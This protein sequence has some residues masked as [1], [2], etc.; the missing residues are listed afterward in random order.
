MSVT[1]ARHKLGRLV[2][3]TGMTRAL[4]CFL[5][6]LLLLAL[7]LHGYAASTMLLCAAGHHRSMASADGGHDPA[8]HAAVHHSARHDNHAAGHDNH[9]AGHDNHA[10]GHDNYAAKP[11]S[12]D[13]KCSACAACCTAVYLPTNVI[14]FTAPAPG[15]VRAVPEPTTLVGFVT[16][17]PERPPRPIA[18]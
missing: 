11:A 18:A 17:G 16:D 6:W 4:R 14:D 12:V 8:A 5:T 3:L 15:P 7:P 10:T 1:S 13:A 9:A 2:R